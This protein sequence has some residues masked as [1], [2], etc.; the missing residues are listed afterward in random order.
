MK[1]LWLSHLI[2][3][4]P[5]GGV[6]QRS[7]YLLRE[8]SKHHEIDLLAFNQKD[9]IAPLYKGD[10]ERGLVD[11][12][13]ELS[14][15]CNDV[16]FFDIECDSKAAGKMLLA[17]TSL[18]SRYPYTINW[19]RSETFS[20]TLLEKISRESYDLVHLDT[21]SLDIYRPLLGNLPC[22]LDHHNIESHML[23]RRS[24]QEKS[25]V[26]KAYFFQEGVRLQRFEKR[27]CPEYW[28]HIT[29]S[30][31]DS[32]RLR[33]ITASSDIETI[34]N[35]VDTNFFAPKGLK[36]DDKTLVFVGTMSWYPNIEAAFFI[37]NEIMPRLRLLRSGVRLQIIGANPPEQLRKFALKHDDIDV[38]GF[39]DEVRDYIE[40]A[41]VYVCP[42]MD[43][44]G[45][46]LKILDALAMEKPIIAH[47]IAS[48]GIN[49]TDGVD[50][51]LA[52]QADEY[53]ELIVRLIESSTERVSLG[54]AARKLALEQYDYT[55]IGKSLSDYYVK[56]AGS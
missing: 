11:A 51:L 26:K 42:I 25:L 14:K 43:G 16:E 29:C 1:L 19:L 4:P 40:K 6:L 27:V 35:G 31:I 39:V 47:K 48:E 32:E 52:D 8:L 44:G 46:K 21:I 23:L 49:V 22:V 9:L 12:H 28:G 20:K 38:L 5:K 3:Y 33:M 54:K 41:T 56:L 15:I 30:D 17:L 2:P 45:T 24:R 50:I 34:P 10:I 36:Q 13:Q 7:F 37:C 18:F 53:A 55:F